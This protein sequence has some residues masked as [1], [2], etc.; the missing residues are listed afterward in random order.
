MPVQL[1]LQGAGNDAQARVRA[2]AVRLQRISKERVH[3][4]APSGVQDG[5][6]HRASR[7]N[8]RNLIEVAAWREPAGRL[9]HAGPA[10]R[11]GSYGHAAKWRHAMKTRP[12]ISP[13]QRLR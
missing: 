12:T 5:L 8:A 11:F 4:G 3:L 9:S 10:P 6:D 1:N 13:P 7:S 2:R